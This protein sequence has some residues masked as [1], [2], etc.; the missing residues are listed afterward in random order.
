MGMC[1]SRY[2]YTMRGRPAPRFCPRDVFISVWL[3]FGNTALDLSGTAAF[4]MSLTLRC[5]AV[6]VV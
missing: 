5:E 2:V 6:L 4:G 3:S 1:P